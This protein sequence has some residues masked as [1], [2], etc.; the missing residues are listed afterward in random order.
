MSKLRKNI[1]NNEWA[2]IANERSMRPY[3]YNKENNEEGCPFCPGNEEMTPN[4][5]LRINNPDGTWNIRVVPNKFP[6]VKGLNEIL[7]GQLETFCV[8][9]KE[10]YHEVVI[11]TPLHNKG[12]NEL[13]E[14]NIHTIFN[15]FRDRFIE[16]SNFKNISHVQIFK[17]SGKYGGASIA[18]S[19]SQIVALP[20]IPPR[21]QRALNNCQ[22]YYNEKK[23]CVICDIINAEL[24]RDIRVIY[25]NDGFV[26]CLSFAPRFSYETVIF[27]LSHKAIFS[28]VTNTEISLLTDA[29]YNTM[30]L[31]SNVLNDFPYNIVL[32]TAPF[33]YTSEF[34]WHLEIIPRIMHHAGMELATG[35]FVNTISPEEAVKAIKEKAT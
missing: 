12:M 31:L 10:G 8:S 13:G 33:K 29:F 26:S 35:I 21:L 19:H 27:P 17:N 34:H 23:K 14:D 18:H 4:E 25:K 24:E 30:K 1:L 15:V 7:E 3:Q 22:N 5:I 2:I 32:N 20:V 9:E 6:A 28:D 11:E 16:L